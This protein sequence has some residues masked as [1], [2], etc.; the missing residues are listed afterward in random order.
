VLKASRAQTGRQLREAG[1]AGKAA[2]AVTVPPEPQPTAETLAAEDKA[3]AETKTYLDSGGKLNGE[4][5]PYSGRLHDAAAAGYVR[6]AKLLIDHGADVNANAARG[7]ARRTPLHHAATAEMAALLIT[8]GAKVDARDM[9]GA[10]PLHTAALTGTPTVAALLLAR[11]ASAGATDNHGRTPLHSVGEM[12]HSVEREGWLVVAR[13]LVA[14]GADVNAR[15]EVP[16]P[17]LPGTRGSIVSSI[18]CRAAPLHFACRAGSDE[19]VEFLIAQ[20]APVDA[21]DFRGNTPLHRA[22]AWGHV[23]VVKL[24]LAAGAR[25]DARNGDYCTPLDLAVDGKHKPAAELLK[26]DGPRKQ[27]DPTD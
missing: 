24:L 22:A 1:R 11:G 9:F 3:L 21:R 5:K 26:P 25:R 27:R 19:I 14:H 20:G 4:L 13:L 10:T 8:H 6:V 2:A 18:P 23:S 15:T 7:G 12:G 17:R 16:K